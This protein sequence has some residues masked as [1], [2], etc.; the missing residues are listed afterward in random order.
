LPRRPFL[1]HFPRRGAKKIS[2]QGFNNAHFRSEKL[3]VEEAIKRQLLDPYQVDA[4]RR[5]ER[6]VT[7][8]PDAR[9]GGKLL[10]LF[11][12]MRRGLVADTR[13]IRLLE[14]QIATG[15]LIDPRAN[16]RVPISVAFRRGL[17]DA[18]TNNKLEDPTDDTKGFFDPNTQENL[19]YIELIRRC[20]KE[21][22]TGYHFLVLRPKRRGEG[23][24]S[25]S[26]LWSKSRESPASRNY[27]HSNARCKTP[28]HVIKSETS[29]SSTIK[30]KSATNLPT[31]HQSKMK[32]LRREDIMFTVPSGIVRLTELLDCGCTDETAVRELESGKVTMEKFRHSLEHFLSGLPPIGGVKVTHGNGTI[33]KLTIYEAQRRQLINQDLSFYLLE[34]QAATGGLCGLGSPRRFDLHTGFEQGL[35]DRELISDL[36]NGLSA[37]LGFVGRNR[38]IVSTMEAARIGMISED[39]ARRLLF[40]QIVTG[41]IFNTANGFRLPLEVA[42]KRAMWTSSWNNFAPACYEFNGK[43]M[44]YEQLCAKCEKDENSR[45]LLLSVNQSKISAGP[46]IMSILGTPLS[47]YHG[48]SF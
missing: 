17:F 24:T 38:S 41:G 26:S 45:C 18:E 36:T 14:A 37:V 40:T 43:A 21:P 42:T 4:L 19:T 16:H 28:E 31:S 27:N 10:S 13:A 32:T 11:E 39:D 9:A 34:A 15:G 44:T 47:F 20:Q 23:R 48:E 6:A 1:G 46:S 8:W 3:S 33:E 35:I 30:S 29:T 2:R 7:G 12:A 22:E 5:A 25:R